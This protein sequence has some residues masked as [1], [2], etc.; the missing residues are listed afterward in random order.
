MS[1]GDIV[2]E[3][4]TGIFRFLSRFFFE[5]FFNLLL[6]FIIQ[7]T[8]YVLLRL[9][10]SKTKPSDTASE[11]VGMLFWIGAVVGGF[12]LYRHIWIT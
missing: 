3:A 5:I 11:I 10:R 4:L 8:G 12:W 1:I 6:K 7:G 9:F 2:G